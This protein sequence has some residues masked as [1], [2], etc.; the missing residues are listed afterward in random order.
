VHYHK[1]KPVVEEW[2]KEHGLKYAYF[3]TLVQNVAATCRHLNTLGNP[4]EPKVKAG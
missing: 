3:P 1:L 2:C 4:D